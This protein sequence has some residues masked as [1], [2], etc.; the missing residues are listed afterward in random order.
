[1]NKKFALIGL[2]VVLFAGVAVAAGLFLFPY[3]PDQ[4]PVV[5]DIGST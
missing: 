3:Q 2:V 4:P 1:M 5:N